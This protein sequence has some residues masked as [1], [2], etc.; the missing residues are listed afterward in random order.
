[1]W[2]S[3][4]LAGEPLELLRG[5][6]DPGGLGRSLLGAGPLLRDQHLEQPQLRPEVLGH[7]GRPVHRPLGAGGPVSGDHDPADQGLDLLKAWLCE[8]R[9]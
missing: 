4:H 6:S 3:G 9:G 2:R 1:M 7:P 5:E 8:R